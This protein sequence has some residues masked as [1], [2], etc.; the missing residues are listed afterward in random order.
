MAQLS[1]C[2]E[3]LFK[4]YPFLDR[5]DM[6]ADSGFPAIEFWSWDNKDI[7]AIK[8]RARDTG[9]KIAGF[10]GNMAALNSEWKQSPLVPERRSEFLEQIKR[11]VDVAHDLDCHTVI[12]MAGKANPDVS[13]EEQRQNLVESLQ[14][15]A[16]IVDGGLVN[17]ALE[18][19]NNT[20]NHPGYFLNTSSEAWQ[21]LSEVNSDRVKL[22]YD[23]Y[24]IQIME[25]NL[26]ANME[27]HLDQL[28]HVHI[29]D[30]PGRYEPGT[31][32]INYYNV[33]RWINDQ[34]YKGYMG[35]EY[36]ITDDTK[37]SLK[38]VREVLGLGYDWQF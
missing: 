6:A 20:V 31:G 24:H 29:G 8:S 4:E 5:I 27:G 19:L 12:V 32:E 28:G 13:R 3:M 17:L 38:R 33:L 22:L 23:I 37:S 16:E 25:G 14:A 30:V 35:L 15:A 10:T 11:G 21:I 34:G 18:P 2:I 9:V 1:V 26:I 36:M 7:A